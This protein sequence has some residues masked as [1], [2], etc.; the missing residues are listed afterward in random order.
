[1][2]ARLASVLVIAFV[3]G[4]CG[5]AEQVAAPQSTEADIELTEPV[6]VTLWHNQSG[7]LAKGFADMIGEF[8]R[9]NGKKITV[10]PEFQGN[11]T[12]IYQ[13]TLGAI[14]AGALPEGI[15]AVENQVADYAK[16]GVVV[17][18][19]PYVSS[20]RN[21]L[22]QQSLDDIYKPYLDSNRYPQYG[23]AILSFPF[24][25]SLEVNFQNDD[26]LKELGQSSPKTWE[27]F[28]RVARA[29]KRAG[30]DGKV[31]RWGWMTYGT[32]NFLAQVLTRG[33]RILSEDG[34][35]V[36]W[37][38]GEGLATLQLLDRCV[39]EEW[40]YQPKGFDWQNQF[41]SG[42]LLFATGTSTGRPFIK[43]AFKKPIAWS[44]V[45]MPAQ[46]PAQSRTIQFGGVIAVMK[47]T[48]PKQLA[49]WEFLKWFTDTKQTAKWAMVSSYMP[50][51]KAAAEDPALRAHYGGPDPQGKQAFDLVA[52]SVPGPSIR[53]WQEVRD[54]VFEMI[55]KVVTR[56]ATPEQALKDGAAKANQILKDNQ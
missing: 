10:K 56:T 31:N 36:G 15:V 28:E 3:V 44:V 49:V 32:E 23:N 9:T 51:R 54:A 18:L 16:A 41:G 4:A 5:P 1:M 33:G 25:K 11:Y 45:G 40:C 6:E 38:G 12:Q 27:E 30:P 43:A 52:T 46:P 35:T 55:T 26:L 34:R 37:G 42:D 48:A 21:G 47:T 39:R 2:R 19:G 13:K 7:E 14:Q 29:A 22:S 20:K 17:D 24:I 53:G 8:N 50:I